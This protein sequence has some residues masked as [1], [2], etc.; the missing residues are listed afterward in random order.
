MGENT[1][2][3][4]SKK[5]YLNHMVRIEL[6]ILA[7]FFIWISSCSGLG[8]DPDPV[9]QTQV[10]AI[11]LYPD[12]VAVGDTVLIDCIIKDSLDKSFKFYWDL[13]SPIEV[14]RLRRISRVRKIRNSLTSR[15]V[16]FQRVKLSAIG[17]IRRRT[18]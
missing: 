15:Y 6:F 5:T 4:Y 10:L 14:D 9:P 7:I 12:T 17:E 16:T 11:N 13:S 2:V 8:P 18:I 3:N 1:S